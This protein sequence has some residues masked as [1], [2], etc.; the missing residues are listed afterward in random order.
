MVSRQKTVMIPEN[1]FEVAFEGDKFE[2]VMGGPFYSATGGTF[3]SVMCGTFELLPSTSII[4]CTYHKIDIKEW[5]YGA[6]SQ[7]MFH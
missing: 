5:I 7:K 3:E 4:E 6:K 2:T 1:D